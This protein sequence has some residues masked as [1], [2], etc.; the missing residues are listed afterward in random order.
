MK[1]LNLG[2]IINFVIFT[3]VTIIALLMFAGGVGHFITKIGGL[4]GS[5]RYFVK[6]GYGFTQYFCEETQL[7]W[8]FNLEDPMRDAYRTLLQF[9][10]YA[11]ES[12]DAKLL[13]INP[14]S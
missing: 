1:I 7:C 2:G 4:S 12:R 9:G 5:I 3:L 11:D 13:E 10:N 8:D 6:F 14:D